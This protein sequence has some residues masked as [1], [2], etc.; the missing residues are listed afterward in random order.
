MV[1]EDTAKGS[2]LLTIQLTGTKSGIPVESLVPSLQRIFPRKT[3]A[4]I[5]QA[6]NRLPVV[7]ARGVQREQALKVK[8]FLEAG[9]AVLKI[10]ASKPPAPATP[11]AAEPAKPPAPKEAPVEPA[12]GTEPTGAERRKKPRVHPGIDLQ[13]MGI[14]DILDKSFRLLRQYFWL[15]FIIVLIPQGCLF[16]VQKGATILAGPDV[17]QTMGLAAGVG[18]GIGLLIGIPVFVVLQFWAQGALIYAVS[19]TYLGHSTSIRGSFGAM[20]RLI[21][22]LL[23]TMILWGIFVFGP[24]MLIGIFMAILMPLLAAAGT[25]NWVI[26]ILIFIAVMVCL[27]LF[28]RLFLNWL[29][30]DKVVVLEAKGGMSAL[31]RS[32]ELMTSSVE[33]GF[34]KK[35]KSKGAL[36]LFVGFLLA[37]GFQLV[38]QIPMSVAVFAAPGNI[39]VLTIGE[40]LNIAASCLATVFTAIAMILFYYDIRLRKEG[41]DLRMMA[42]NL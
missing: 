2:D 29:L 8:R 14:G 34:G 42:E 19:E 9:G 30:V 28:F 12:T 18:I 41:F 39:F 10:T 17:G 23:G 32:K 25:N 22:K 21:W 31:H 36:I 4:Q 40:I 33:S 26:G 16:L 27:W 11:A 5:R 38:F 37:M 35:P 7:L 1:E 13:P 15:F 6:L 20:R 24:F 3:E